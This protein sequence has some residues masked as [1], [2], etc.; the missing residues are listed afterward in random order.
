MAALVDTGLGSDSEQPVLSNDGS[1]IA[2]VS[3]TQPT[4]PWKYYVSRNGG[5]TEIGTAGDAPHAQRPAV[6]P[7]G[8]KVAFLRFTAAT[9]WELWAVRP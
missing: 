1:T 5:L 7:D 2:F 9:G 3:G 6:S 4:G 8:T